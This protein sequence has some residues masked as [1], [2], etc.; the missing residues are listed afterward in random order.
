MGQLAAELD[1]N[2]AAQFQAYQNL[3]SMSIFAIGPDAL[4]RLERDHARA[5]TKALDP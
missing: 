3:H 5:R 1:G 2:T 4:L